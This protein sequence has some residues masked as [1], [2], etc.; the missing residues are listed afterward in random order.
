MSPLS[1]T[2]TRNHGVP[3]ALWERQQQLF[4]RG[5]AEARR[6]CA[7]TTNANS[8]CTETSRFVRVVRVGVARNFRRLWELRSQGAGPTKGQRPRWCMKF[9][10]ALGTALAGRSFHKR[11]SDADR[12]RRSL[13]LS[14]SF[15]DSASP[16]EGSCRP[17]C[18]GQS[19]NS[20]RT[21]ATYLR[22]T[23]RMI[24]P[25]Q[26]QIWPGNPSR[27]ASVERGKSL[28]AMCLRNGTGSASTVGTPVS[29]ST[30][31]SHVHAE[32]HP[33]VVRHFVGV[34]P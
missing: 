32:R 10:S 9:Q 15:R 2:E 8:L 13:Q 17:P 11:V 33:T 6:L 7:Q 30:E 28:C 5:G 29:P 22:R 16:C 18:A 20:R 27:S 24:L 23:M 3:E 21:R 1:H 34:L 26:R 14:R 4:S 25:R 31:D 12:A 19:R